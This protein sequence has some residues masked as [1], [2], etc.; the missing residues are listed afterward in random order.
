MWQQWR[1]EKPH[2]KWAGFGPRSIRHSP[3][4]QEIPVPTLCC[5]LGQVSPTKARYIL[6]VGKPAPLHQVRGLGVPGSGPDLW[7]WEFSLSGQ[8]RSS[9]VGSLSH[10]LPHLTVYLSGPQLHGCLHCSMYRPGWAGPCLGCAQALLPAR[11]GCP[12]SGWEGH[13]TG[14]PSWE[15]PGGCLAPGPGVSLSTV[16]LPGGRTA[17]PNLLT[18]YPSLHRSKEVPPSFLGAAFS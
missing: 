7:G 2:L 1:L 10:S 12:G 9:Q 4:R 8:W 11:S 15:A 16:A 5:H 14:G 17:R 18:T 13:F 3:S 6:C